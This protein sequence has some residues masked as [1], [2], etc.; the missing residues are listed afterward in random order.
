LQTLRS[1]SQVRLPGVTPSSNDPG[2]RS[3]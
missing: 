1:E 2:V 3:Q